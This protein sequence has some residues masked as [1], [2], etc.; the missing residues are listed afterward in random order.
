MYL[1]HRATVYIIVHF[2]CNT[3]RKSDVTSVIS[4]YRISEVEKVC[5]KTLTPH[6]L[7]KTS[8]PRFSL[9][10]CPDW[11]TYE[12][13]GQVWTSSIL[14]YIQSNSMIHKET[15]DTAKCIQ[16]FLD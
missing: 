5:L 10:F 13:L 11:L 9:C 3:H 15:L 16:V 4:C 14:S 2:K 7:A 6:S 12:D 8:R 1:G